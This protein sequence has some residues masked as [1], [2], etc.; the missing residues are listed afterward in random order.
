MKARYLPAS[1]LLAGLLI[2]AS[3]NL[4]LAQWAAF[5]STGFGT[6]SNYHGIDVPVGEAVTS[7]AGWCPAYINPNSQE[8]GVQFL[9]VTFVW[10]DPANNTVWTD[11]VALQGPFTTGI[12]PIPSNVPKEILDWYNANPGAV[13]YYAQDTHTPTGLGDWGVQAIFQ[14]HILKH[15]GQTELLHVTRGTS[16][17]VIPEVPFGTIAILVGWLGV[18]GIFALRRKHFPS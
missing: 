3:V 7:T 18:L 17:N 16:M 15:N 8:Y 14:N 13:W 4:V 11:R 1:V 2:F 10:H 5:E 9:T 12:D 6:T